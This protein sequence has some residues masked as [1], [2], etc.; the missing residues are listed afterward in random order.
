MAA[1]LNTEYKTREHSNSAN[2]RQGHN[3]VGEV[4]HK[5]RNI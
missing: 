4:F 1:Q 5:G 2:L 3:L